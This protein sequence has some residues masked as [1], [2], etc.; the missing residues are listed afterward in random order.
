MTGDKEEDMKRHKIS[1]ENAR[2]SIELE[3]QK[4]LEELTLLR[5]KGARFDELNRDFKRLE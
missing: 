3:L 4:A 5:E 2:K 1:Y